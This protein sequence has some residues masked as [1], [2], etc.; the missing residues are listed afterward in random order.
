[1]ELETTSVD[2][3][4]GDV[5]L[6][7]GCV[8]ARPILLRSKENAWDRT[9]QTRTRLY[10]F[11]ENYCQQHSIEALILQSAPYVHPAWVKFESWIPVGEQ[12]LTARSSMKVTII[13][14]PF[15]RYEQIYNVHWEKDGHISNFENVYRFSEHEA[16]YLLNFLF[17]LP[18]TSLWKPGGKPTFSTL[19]LGE[20]WWKTKNKVIAVRKDLL[21]I[22]SVALMA[23]S[24]FLMLDGI[25]LIPILFLLLGFGGWLMTGMAPRLTRSAGK[26]LSEPRILLL[27]DS[28]QTVLFGAGEDAEKIRARLMDHFRISHQQRFSCS[29]ERI[30]RWGLDGKTEREQ[31]VLRYER[32]LV[33]CQVYEYG[34][35][36]YVG[37]DAQL[38][39]GTWK[40]KEIAKGID[41]ETGKRVR[42]MSVEQAVQS[43]SEYD[44]VD[45]NCLLEWTHAQMMKVIKHYV[46]ERQIDQEIDFTIIRGDRQTVTRQDKKQKKT[47]R[48]RRKG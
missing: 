1:M 9:E 13:T 34:S 5:I 36:L 45:L 15:H 44:L 4:A 25:S 26:P 29:I 14:M 7:S 3:P 33:F 24:V 19:Q 40:E 38:N 27:L 32:G 8:D 10:H 47:S 37:W 39:V 23:L 35:D 22:G 18:K 11:I 46:R 16:T 20:E 41:R 17:T 43:A 2:H 30:W 31:V 6:K 28:W 48:F 42:V 21:R 12:H